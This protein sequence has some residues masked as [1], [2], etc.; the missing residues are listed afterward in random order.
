MAKIFFLCRVED[1]KFSALLSDR[2]LKEQTLLGIKKVCKHTSHSRWESM[3]NC[4][5]LCPH[6]RHHIQGELKSVNEI[7]N[8]K[9]RHSPFRGNQTLKVDARVYAYLPFDPGEGTAYTGLHICTLSYT[10]L[11]F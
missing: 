10:F 5:S 11:R 6:S 7:E 4:G 3:N 9:L 2:T 8:K 1:V